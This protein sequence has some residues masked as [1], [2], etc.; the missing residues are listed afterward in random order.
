ME[1]NKTKITLD[2]NEYLLLPEEIKNQKL[3]VDIIINGKNVNDKVFGLIMK[4]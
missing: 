2:V 1:I 4:R 3:K